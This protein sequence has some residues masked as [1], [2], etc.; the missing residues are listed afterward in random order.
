[1]SKWTSAAPS[2]GLCK[3]PG[4][5][6]IRHTLYPRKVA[7][8]SQIFL[9]DT[10]ILSKYI[11]LAHRPLIAVHLRYECILI[12]VWNTRLFIKNLTGDLLCLINIKAKLLK[13]IFMT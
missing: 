11:I 8:T 12:N 3:W 5:T 1:M 13:I 2:S 4:F 10:Y 6:Y 9:H 7:D